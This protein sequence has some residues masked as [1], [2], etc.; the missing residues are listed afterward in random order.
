[1][2]VRTT[3]VNGFRNFASFTGKTENNN[4]SKR[5]YVA[6]GQSKQL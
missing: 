5:K 6:R 1:M 4:E 2:E 3:Q